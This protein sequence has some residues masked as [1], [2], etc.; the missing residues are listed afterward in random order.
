MT[1]SRIQISPLLSALSL[2]ESGRGLFRIDVR[3]ARGPDRS[4]LQGKQNDDDWG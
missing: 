2:I 1:H 4:T 3:S